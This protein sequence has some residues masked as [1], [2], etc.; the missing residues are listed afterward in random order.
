VSGNLDLRKCNDDLEMYV[1]STAYDFYNQLLRE[2]SKIDPLQH[3][4]AV[5][6]RQMCPLVLADCISRLAVGSGLPADGHAAH[7]MV[8]A[9]AKFAWM[10]PPGK[11]K[12]ALGM[13]QSESLWCLVFIQPELEK[14]VCKRK[15][16]F[17]Q[18]SDLVE[19]LDS[20]LVGKLTSQDT[21]CERPHVLALLGT[22]PAMYL[23]ELSSENMACLRLQV[24]W[25]DACEFWLSRQ[26]EEAR[27]VREV[28]LPDAVGNFG[29][30]A[31]C[32]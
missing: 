21:R 3:Q 8:A 24:T 26:T 27:R 16:Q 19:V 29:T 13:A 22:Q 5:T 20:G 14:L 17:L 1:H 30:S 4:K 9:L 11:M 2:D 23:K 32:L 6:L 25:V 18:E 15:E 7:S 28:H 31:P 12:T 10:G